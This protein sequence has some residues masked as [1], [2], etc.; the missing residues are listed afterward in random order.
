MYEEKLSREEMIALVQKI[1]RAEG[2]E[3]EQDANVALFQANCQHSGGTDLI[4]WP[5]GFPHDPAKPEPTAAEIVDKAMS[6]SG[7]IRL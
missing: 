5:H 4:F 1:M 7:V 3:A 2:T 6:Q